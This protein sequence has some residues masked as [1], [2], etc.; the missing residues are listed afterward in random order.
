MYATSPRD[1]EIPLS[2]FPFLPHPFPKKRRAN[3]NEKKTTLSPLERKH[4]RKNRMR[5][6]KTKT[7][8]VF[9]RS[10]YIVRAVLLNSS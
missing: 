3:K 4:S 7:D 5:P 2:Q 1:T 9:Q 8:E 6:G 10:R